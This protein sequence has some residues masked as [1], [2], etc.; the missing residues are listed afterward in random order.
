MHER[1]RSN[2]SFRDGSTSDTTKTGSLAI[3]DACDGDLPS[4][5]ND[6]DSASDPESEAESN[7]HEILVAFS[8]G[9]Q[10]DPAVKFHSYAVDPNRPHN[11]TD[12]NLTIQDICNDFDYARGGQT[13]PLDM[14]LHDKTNSR[15][16]WIRCGGTDLREGVKWRCY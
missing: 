13:N 12:Y 8:D 3:S 14:W 9:A 7:K 1:T 11:L 10:F 16:D 5:K 15:N 2:V 6:V 4:L